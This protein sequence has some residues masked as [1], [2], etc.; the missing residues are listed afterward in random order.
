MSSPSWCAIEQSQ[1]G[2][3]GRFNYVGLRLPRGARRVSSRALQYRQ[4]SCL[5]SF[6]ARRSSSVC[7]ASASAVACWRTTNSATCGLEVSGTS[8]NGDSG[9]GEGLVRVSESKALALVGAVTGL[10]TRAWEPN[11]SVDCPVLSDRRRGGIVYDVCV[12]R[13]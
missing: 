10:V 8:E 5:F 3:L 7:G 6:N 4:I 9:V 11:D 2:G 12:V 1:L 13:V